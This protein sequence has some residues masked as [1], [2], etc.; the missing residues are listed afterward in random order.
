MPVLRIPV[1]EDIRRLR[2][3]RQGAEPEAAQHSRAVWLLSLRDQQKARAADA[4][5]LQALAV[6]TSDALEAVPATVSGRIDE[7]SG[8]AIEIGLSVAREIVGSALDQGA[9]DVTPTVARCLR[10][11]VHGSG[12]GELT[13]CL[14]PEDLRVAQDQ[15]ADHEDLRPQLAAA[16]FVADPRAGRGSVRVETEAGR[17]KYDPRDVLQRISDEVR[18]EV[19]A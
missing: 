10:D 4:A 16:R 8:I 17:L 1:T 7:I 5:A 9:V 11:C 3:H 13:I 15:L 19:R 18:R 12:S 6:A 14:H 2:L